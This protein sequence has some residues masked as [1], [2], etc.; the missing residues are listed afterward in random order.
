MPTDI[1]AQNFTSQLTR[2]FTENGLSS[3]LN[4]ERCEQFYALTVRMLEEN[5]K[6]NLTA[7][8]EPDKIILAHY[9]DCAAIASS[10]DVGASLIDVGCGAGFPTLPLAIVRPDL[11]IF[12]LD[13]TAKRIN[14][15]KETARLLSLTGVKA[16]AMRAEDAAKMPEY[17]EKFDYATARAV[18][19]L[20][21][22]AELTL[23]FVRPGGKLIAMKGKNAEF[24]LT[25][26]KRALAILGGRDA[27]SK[28]IVLKSDTETLSH[29]II[30][31]QKKERTPATYPR[32]FAQISKKPL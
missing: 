29:P 15:V 11:K 20:R 2:V 17:R 14:Y 5:E 27:K 4:K 24:E 21:V 13:S 7:I 19:E 9:A 16:E 10:F 8:K 23:P 3:L 18:A 28:E 26:A 31:V 6:Y 32:A 30:T 25:A 12:A 22:L 1:N